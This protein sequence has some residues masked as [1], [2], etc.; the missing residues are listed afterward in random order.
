[1]TD[2]VFHYIRSHPE[3]DAARGGRSICRD[4]F[5][6]HFLYGHYA[7]AYTW[8]KSL[9]NAPVQDCPFL[10]GSCETK[11]VPEQPLLSLIRKVICDTVTGK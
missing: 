2:I 7:L 4:G 10:P 5:H 11:E 3:F 6:M 9:L 1:M 8:A